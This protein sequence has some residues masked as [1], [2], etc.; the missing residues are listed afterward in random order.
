MRRPADEAATSATATKSTRQT[1]VQRLEDAL[2]NVE[3]AVAAARS[4]EKLAQDKIIRCWRDL[5]DS[6]LKC[7][8]LQESAIEASKKPA[9][10]PKGKQKQKLAQ[11]ARSTHS[12]GPSPLPGTPTHD[13]R[14]RSTRQR[15][16]ELGDGHN[17][18]RE[19]DEE[20]EEYEKGGDDHGD[21]DDILPPFAI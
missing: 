14:R 21:D 10:T 16:L 13:T 5:V 8:E 3:E 18:T 6:Y 1:P 12:P 20:E 15:S 4:N 11:D 7:V 19:K 2:R 9:R 17:Q